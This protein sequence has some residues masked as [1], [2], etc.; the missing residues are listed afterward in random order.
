MGSGPKYLFETFESDAS[1]FDSKFSD[2]INSKYE[3]GWEY[4]NCQ[5]AMESGRRSAY[6]L[7][8]RS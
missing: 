5:F 8:E 6:C 7:F 3:N 1:N 2:Y 4:E